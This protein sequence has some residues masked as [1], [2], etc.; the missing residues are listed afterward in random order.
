MPRRDL[1]TS[2]A[3]AR[4][5]PILGPMAYYMLKL[6][7]V[8][9]PRSVP[10]GAD[11]E[12][13][14]GGYGVVIHSKSIIGH[15]VKIYPG[16]TLGRTDIYNPIADSKFESI[17]I[18]DDVILSPGC[19]ILCKAGVLRVGQ[20]TVIGANAVLLSSTGENEIWAGIPAR[21]VGSR[22]P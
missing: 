4:T 22:T 9:L 6:L 19:K 5:W 16:V 3:Y 11:L 7:G 17:V 13:A 12:I 14:H 20:G 18:E 21:V 2:L 8:E 1:I 15:R 10:I